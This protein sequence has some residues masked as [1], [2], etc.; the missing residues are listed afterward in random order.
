MKRFLCFLLAISFVV[1]VSVVPNFVE[2]K[3]P[4]Q[5]KYQV[6]G[7]ARVFE[8]TY[9]YRIKEGDKEIVKGFGTASRGGPDWGD[10]KEVIKIPQN[11]GKD[12]TLELYEINQENGEE[13]N[14][15][16]IPLN[17]IKGKVF[18]NKIFR[19]VK[20]RKL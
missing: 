12:L 20:V 11:T 19:N 3:A 8:G 15:L 6:T 16:I 7:Q 9:N 5:I 13:A 4:T 14:K 18:Q 2:A 17:K 10:F 1:T